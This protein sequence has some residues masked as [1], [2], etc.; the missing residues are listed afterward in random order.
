MPNN[1]SPDS[2]AYPELKLDRNKRYP[3]RLA[4]TSF[5]YRAGYAE[6]VALLAPHFDEI[7]LLFFE[8]HGSQS[9]PSD[10]LV[11]ELGSLAADNDI[12]Y[13]VHLP[14]DI[15][16]GDPQNAQRQHAIRILRCGRLGDKALFPGG[17]QDVGRFVNGDLSAHVMRQVVFCHGVK[18]K[19]G[20]NDLATP[21]VQDIRLFPADTFCHYDGTFAL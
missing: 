13:N 8:S 2:D 1:F 3:F 10:E 9:C 21:L 15:S 4:T 5:I 20:I 18:H 6:N 17:F 7:E 16:P 11:D 14:I 12:T 19:A